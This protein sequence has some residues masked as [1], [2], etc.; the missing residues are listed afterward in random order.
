M[1][2]IDRMPLPKRFLVRFITTKKAAI[3]LDD[4][5]ADALRGIGLSAKATRLAERYKEECAKKNALMMGEAITSAS[6]EK[7]RPIEFE[8][9][10]Y[11]GRVPSNCYLSHIFNL[12]VGLLRPYLDAEVLIMQPPPPLPPPAPAPPVS[13]GPGAAAV[14]GA[15]GNAMGGRKRARSCA[16]PECRLKGL[17]YGCPGRKGIDRCPLATPELVS[18]RK[19]RTCKKCGKTSDDCKGANGSQHQCILN[20]EDK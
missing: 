19:R 5:L 16:N 18:K 3:Y 17:E 4:L 8:S 13:G 15:A 6:A 9:D 10:N 2:V 20:A 12:V 7:P 14:G 1:T 11:C